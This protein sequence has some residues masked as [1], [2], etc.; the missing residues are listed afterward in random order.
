MK[1]HHLLVMPLSSMPANRNPA[2]HLKFIVLS[3][4]PERSAQIRRSSMQM[5]RMTKSV[6]MINHAGALPR[7][8]RVMNRP[9]MTG[10]LRL[11]GNI[12]RIQNDD[13]K[14][15]PVNL[16]KRLRFEHPQSPFR[17]S[18]PPVP[19]QRLRQSVSF[20]SRQNTFLATHPGFSD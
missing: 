19:L 13:I 5:I 8:F 16:C 14:I 12:I 1:R 3:N 7:I 6:F 2:I 15:T 9:V 18:T 10:I 4:T 11:D 20:P 17:P